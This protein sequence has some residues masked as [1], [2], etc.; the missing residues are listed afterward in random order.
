MDGARRRAGPANRA[1]G[2]LGVFRLLRVMELKAVGGT[3]SD[4]S[5][6]TGT[7]ALFGD[8]DIGA[9]IEMQ[10][11]GLH[12]NRSH[13]QMEVGLLLLEERAH[14]LVTPHTLLDPYGLVSHHTLFDPH[15]LVSH[16]SLQLVHVR[17]CSFI[18][19]FV[20]FI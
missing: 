14:G 5:S 19:M 16:L 11:L 20:V 3:V 4:R 7:A 1:P 18:T 17:K 6:A 15:G 13:S 10:W 9:M 2:V 8:L 12:L